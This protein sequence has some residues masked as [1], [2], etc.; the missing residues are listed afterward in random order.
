MLDA[1]GR[2]LGRMF[3]DSQQ[4][5]KIVP[6]WPIPPEKESYRI[7]CVSIACMELDLGVKGWIWDCGLAEIRM[8]A[9]GVDGV[10]CVWRRVQPA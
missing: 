3:T 10:W 6:N 8:R 5:G 2:F 1:R 4:I 7:A 9:G